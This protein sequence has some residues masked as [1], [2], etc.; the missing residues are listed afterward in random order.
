MVMPRAFSSGA[1]SIWSNAITCTFG[2]CSARTLV[3]AAVSVVLPWSM[4]PI[5]PTLRC[6][7]VRSNFCL[8]IG[9]PLLASYPGNDLTGDR[10]GHLLV[11]VELHRVGSA[12]LGARPQVGSV[13]EHVTEGHLALDDLARTALLDALDPAPPAGDVADDVAHVVVGRHHLDGHD[14]LEEHG[15]GQAGGLLDGEGAGDLERH[16]RRVHVV[17]GAVDQR[18]P[19]VDHR[20][21][22]QHAALQRLLDAGVD[23]GDVLLGDD[24]ADDLVDELVAAAGA[25]GLDVEDDVAVLAPTAGL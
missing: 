6:G 16:L 12:T 20:V 11:G 21:P 4:W 7:L 10:L 17:V 15:V 8:A 3:I 2:F 18:G 19:D 25:R 5:V 13:S 14:G 23:G 22:G 24:A 9:V 1:L